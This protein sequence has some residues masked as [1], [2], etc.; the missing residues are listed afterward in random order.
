MTHTSKSGQE[1]QGE[2]FGD[3]VP[4]LPVVMAYFGLLLNVLCPGLGTAVCGLSVLCCGFVQPEE[5]GRPEC[6]RHCLGTGLLQ[7]LS[8]PLLLLGWIWGVQWALRC[9]SI[10]RE[11]C[12]P[13]IP[14]SEI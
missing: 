1:S 10:A 2:A 6:A 14:S 12:D 5:M 7:L 8:T 9:L 13:S 4:V 3:C 11:S